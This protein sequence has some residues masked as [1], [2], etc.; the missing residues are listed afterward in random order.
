MS[1]SGGRTS[2]FMLRQILDAHGGQL[3]ND[4]HVLFANTGKERL[5]TLDFVQ[6]CSERWA[7]RV[8]WVEYHQTQ[9]DDGKL[10]HGWRE[11]DYVTA[12]RLGEPFDALI[13]ARSF[14]PN[15]VMR[16]CTQELKIR[17]MNK[18]ARS[19]GFDHWTSVIGLRAD[20]PRRVANATAPTKERWEI[21]CPLADAGVT[22][23][24]V[25]AFWVRQP[26]NLRLKSHEGNCDLC[27][28]KARPKLERIM[29][30]HPE[31]VPWW[32]E[33]EGPDGSD[34]TF[35]KDRPTYRRMLDVV[36]RTPFLPGLD[37][38]EEEGTLPCAC[39]D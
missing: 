17:P 34:L 8:R 19:I 16:F 5:E 33:K 1:F 12:S 32:S 28:L 2:A 13:R 26:F 18:F 24:D 25:L 39:T 14:L 23:G 29:R 20:E 22:S 15:P 7:V 35:R 38:D 37:L 27:Y 11:V 30:E 10:A 36:Q 31:L 6:E 9:G 4:V 21:A 3:P